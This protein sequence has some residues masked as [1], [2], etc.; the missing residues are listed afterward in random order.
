MRLRRALV[1]P[2][3]QN[4]RIE[5]SIM[6]ILVFSIMLSFD[7]LRFLN[8]SI[9]RQQFECNDWNINRHSKHRLNK[10]ADENCIFTKVPPN[11]HNNCADEKYNWNVPEGT[12]FQQEML[13]NIVDMKYPLIRS[14][15]GTLRHILKNAD[16]S[17]MLVRGIFPLK[18]L[19]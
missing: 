17:T 9:L 15:H 8:Y 16:E 4:L 19:K 18:P 1:L 10:S 2:L 11:F 6:L 7:S 12:E 5:K 14:K 3:A 13:K